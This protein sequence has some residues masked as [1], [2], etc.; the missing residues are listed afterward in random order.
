MCRFSGVGDGVAGGGDGARGQIASGLT[1]ASEDPA[2]G[3][4]SVSIDDVRARVQI[5]EMNPVQGILAGFRGEGI[6]GP[7]GQAGVDAAAVEF[8]AG[9]AI[10]QEKI[11]VR[12]HVL[13]CL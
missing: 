3:V 2:M 9:C 10:K 12:G 4:K 6:G 5:V 13:R 11:S 1:G 7:Q 8:G